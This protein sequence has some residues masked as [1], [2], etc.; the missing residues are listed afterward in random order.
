ML[1]L[2]LI[3]VFLSF[4]FPRIADDTNALCDL[5]DPPE[6]QLRPPLIRTGVTLGASKCTPANKPITLW[7]CS[8][9]RQGH[10]VIGFPR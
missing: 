9:R 2:I 4:A 8:D 5:P 10:T 3:G 6:W 7:P 1:L